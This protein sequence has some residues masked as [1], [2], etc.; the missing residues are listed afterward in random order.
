MPGR[1]RVF[2]VEFSSPVNCGG[3]VLA[4]AVEVNLVADCE[5]GK[6]MIAMI[7]LTSH[8]IRR[9]RVNPSVLMGL[10]IY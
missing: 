9:R 3:V 2:I 10:E 4:L 5:I 8:H 1:A 7:A 6:G